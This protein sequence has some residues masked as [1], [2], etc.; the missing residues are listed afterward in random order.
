MYIDF[1]NE[2][3]K[4]PL[5]DLDDVNL[6]NQFFN[7]PR[8][9][10]RIQHIEGNRRNLMNVWIFLSVLCIIWIAWILY[11]ANNQLITGRTTSRLVFGLIIWIMWSRAWVQNLYKESNIKKSIMPIFVNHIDSKIQFSTWGGYLDESNVILAEKWIINQYDLEEFTEDSIKFK[12]FEWITIS[13]AEIKTMKETMIKS[14]EDEKYYTINNHCYIIKIEYT[15][16]KIRLLNWVRIKKDRNENFHYIN[17]ISILPPILLTWFIHFILS[18]KWINLNKIEYLILFVIL[19]FIVRSV[20]KHWIGKERTKMENYEFEKKYDVYCDDKI[21][22]RTVLTPSFMYKLMYYADKI[23]PKRI[24]E[25]HFIE[26]TIYIKFDIQKSWIKKYMEFS[27]WKNVNK[28]L[29][30]YV[31]FYLEIKNILDLVEDLNLIYLDKDNI[32]NETL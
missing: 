13:G 14:K 22:S 2:I 10:N 9:Y 12:P 15:N 19:F 30:Q 16:P 11:L 27:F 8:I 24:Y 28:N 4:Y 29:A 31:E 3:N 25:F 23:D 1:T 21:E 26:N 18:N 32:N 5:L 17:L 6:L 20:I 7:E